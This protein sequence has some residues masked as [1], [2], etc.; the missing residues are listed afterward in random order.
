LEAIGHIEAFLREAPVLESWHG[1]FSGRAHGLLLAGGI[2][3][4]CKP[5]DEGGHDEQAIKNEVAAWALAKQLGWGDLMGATVL[6]EV[7]SFQSDKLVLTSI[8]V[9]WHDAT[10]GVDLNGCSDEQLCQAAALDVLIKMADRSG[11]NWLGLPR[12]DGSHRLILVDHAFAFDHA[13]A[14]SLNSQIAALRSGRSLPDTL[15]EAIQRLTERGPTDELRE[16]LPPNS[17]QALLNRARGMVAS[18]TLDPP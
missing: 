1:R 14:G 15:G 17:L 18:G 11:N 6:R 12:A 16:L 4:V 2:Y 13:N 5:S 8:Q 10:P 7:P 9:T 3:T